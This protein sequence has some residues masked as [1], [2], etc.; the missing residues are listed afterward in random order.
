MIV[1]VYFYFSHIC[2]ILLL[3][4]EI[5]WVSVNVNVFDRGTIICNCLGAFIFP[6]LTKFEEKKILS[7]CFKFGDI[8]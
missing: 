7:E 5:N 6:R 2:V 8:F 1:K 4:S 3:L